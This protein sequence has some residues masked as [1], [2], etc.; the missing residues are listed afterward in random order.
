MSLSSYP[1]VFG[2]GHRAIGN[3]LSGPV[4]VEEK[5]DGSQLSF[6]LVDG[7]RMMR[8]KGKSQVPPDKMFD[9]AWAVV[10]SLNLEPGWIY[11]AE[12]LQS[13]HHNV[14][15]YSRVPLQHIVIYDIETGPQ[16]F[17]SP[18]EKAD[19][20]RRLG[21]EVVPLLYSGELAPAGLV[22]FVQF[23]LGRESFLGG[24][25]IEGVVIKNYEQWTMEKKVA[26]GK[27]VSDDFKEAHSTTWG[28][29]TTSF[30]DALG[31]AYRTEARWLKAI[32][33]LREDGLLDD[34]P[35][36]IGPILREIN[37]DILAECGEE[38]RDKLFAHFW[39]DVA[40]ASIR[41]FPEFYKA[42][43]LEAFV[44]P[45]VGADEVAA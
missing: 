24:P 27:Y 38:I 23:H 18:E 3:L 29:P 21:L 42:R 5:V 28:H 15:S 8:S 14:L 16:T 26:I 44:N 9:A 10:E 17:L 6:G 20:A 13:P 35:K 32:Q 11:R 36:D 22:E 33:H 2:I 39:K 1:T 30:M 41:G 40:K 43:L 12:Y 45:V 25:K 37:R 34:S 19:E 4:V 7:E 31:Q